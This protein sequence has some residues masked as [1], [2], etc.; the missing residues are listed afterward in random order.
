MKVSKLVKKIDQIMDEPV[1][2]FN[3]LPKGIAQSLDTLLNEYSEAEIL[4]AMDEIL[5][6]CR[7]NAEQNGIP[8]SC[9]GAERQLMVRLKY[10]YLRDS[11]EYIK[12]KL[13]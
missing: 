1:M 2:S 7:E 10:S 13:T 4:A 3:G 8:G 12:S 11:I 9:M 5:P 6:I